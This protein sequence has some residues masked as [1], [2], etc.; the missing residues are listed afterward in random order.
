MDI[1]FTVHPP[2]FSTVLSHLLLSLRYPSDIN[3]DC[4]ATDSDGSFNMDIVLCIRHC[5]SNS[6]HRKAENAGSK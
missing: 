2:A 6:C 1:V 3:S 4:L 5:E